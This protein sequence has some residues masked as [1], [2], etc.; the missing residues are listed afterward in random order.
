MG[1]VKGTR[2]EANL[3]SSFAGES[4][5]RN[6]YTYF[7]GVAR[8]AGLE[9][10]AAI[11]ADTADNEKEHA[12][13]FF[14]YLEGGAVAITA[15]YPAGVVGDT[16][17]NLRAS[18]AGENEEHTAL[19]PEAAEVADREG[20]PEIAALWRAVAAAEQGHE[21]RFRALVR[22]METGQVFIRAT[23]VTWRC[24]NCGYRHSGT[25]APDRCP[26]C[27]HPQAHFELEATNY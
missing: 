5:A 9:Q 18:A 1:S 3:L 12:K 15:T 23:S 21:A 8:K 6:R 26:A 16:L 24:R 27:R 20:F 13:R 22:N 7:A 10:I 19:Y 25:A 4:Q 14:S 2:T 17:A 11:F